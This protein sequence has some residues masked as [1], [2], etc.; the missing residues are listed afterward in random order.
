MSRCLEVVLMCNALTNASSCLALESTP[1]I[2][3]TVSY[4]C[5]LVSRIPGK[6]Q[7]IILFGCCACYQ[8]KVTHQRLSNKTKDNTQI[9]ADIRLKR[10]NG[11]N[12]ELCT[13]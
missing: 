1:M 3:D 10:N 8:Q 5:S 9:Q 12:I 2:V 7:G 4:M 13:K 6:D 11:E